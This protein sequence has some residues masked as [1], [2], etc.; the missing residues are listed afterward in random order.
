MY[1]R[2]YR[3][4]VSC[5]ISRPFVFRET[6]GLCRLPFNLFFELTLFN[7]CF[8][9]DS[10]G[11]IFDVLIPM[12]RNS[13]GTA[14][15]FFKNMMETADPLKFPAVGFK[16]LSGNKSWMD[17]DNLTPYDNSAGKM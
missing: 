2:L 10:L 17:R 7:S 14:A 12:K 15:E 5:L 8:S 16:S 9:H 4:T 13:H 11:K 6:R 3:H 1:W